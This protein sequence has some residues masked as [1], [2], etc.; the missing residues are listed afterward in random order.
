MQG[1][2]ARAQEFD[3]DSADRAPAEKGD[4]LATS[5]V[6]EAVIGFLNDGALDAAA[7]LIASSSAEVGDA[8]LQAMSE[9][10]SASAGAAQREALA[11]AFFRARDFERAGKAALL[12]DD[13]ERAARFLEQSGQ[14]G[15]AAN[16]HERAGRLEQAAELYERA[17][18]FDRAAALFE[19]LGRLDR[20][21]QAFERGGKL[22]EAGRL[23]TKLR[24]LDRSLEALQRVDQA[25]AHFV[26]AM[27]LLGRILE[28]TG[29]RDA[30]AAR[31]LEVVNSRPLD[32]TTVDIHERLIELYVI[33]GNANDARRL[34]NRVLTFAP[35]RPR[36]AR[37]LG[38]LLGKGSTEATLRS[39][40]P[41]HSDSAPPRST[42]D[43][44]ASSGQI[45]T[46]T[47][48]H[49]TVDSLRK[50]PLLAELS[51]DELR[52]LHALGERCTFSAGQT[53]IEADTDGAH[54]VVLLA[55]SV[56]VLRP[57]PQG[58]IHLAELRYGACLG[59]MALV[60]E[61]PT[62]AHVRALTDVTAFRWPIDVIRKHLLGD[63]RT[64]LRMLR[65]MSRTLSVRLRE[66]NSRIKD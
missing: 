6:R 66:A 2:R 28:Y 38:Q 42:A 5:Q 9:A 63:E 49:P 52:S 12:I 37:A 65:V 59:E 45:G 48:V 35:S 33:A 17:R 3:F 61:G 29:Y 40:G 57:S 26:P 54:F 53:I 56:E 47:A 34:I 23:W 7:S 62:S 43:Q 21:A 58:A 60:D 46:I 50:L 44:P 51:L 36:A 14:F 24:R 20:A 30:A 22:F 39:P 4:F 41:Q 15:R 19:Q 11:E 27:Q 13:P 16:L 1:Q 10:P 25:S 8:L 18:D 55:G 64:A 31:Y 32:Q